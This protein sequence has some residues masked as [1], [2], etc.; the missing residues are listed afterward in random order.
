MEG[1]ESLRKAAARCEGCG[2]CESR[3]PMD[4]PKR[5][6]NALVTSGR[7][8]EAAEL[9]SECTC[10]G[11]C[12][13]R[14]PHGVP[15]TEIVAA[16]R[17]NV[18]YSP[19]EAV[20]KAVKVGSPYGRKE[21]DVNEP[22]EGDVVAVLGCTIRSRRDWTEA[23]VE[24]ASRAGWATLG[25]DEPCC[26]NFARKYGEDVPE[27]NLEAWR[28]LFD[29]YEDVVVFCPGCL[30]MCVEVL[31]RRPRHYA[32]VEKVKFDVPEGAL[33]KSPCHLVRHGVDDSIL[34]RLPVDVPPRRWRCCGGG[35]AVGEPSR[36]V[37]RW[38]MDRVTVTPCPMC[39]RTL[40]KAGVRVVP[41]WTVARV[42]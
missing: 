17:R 40:E 7:L 39:A 28:E 16:V 37:D 6:F 19:R 2:A 3:C 9:V 29:E 25:T 23:A 20:R 34:A 33:Y 42:R 8:D 13:E 31:G 18:G 21:E 38:F 24:L 5:L 22:L 27:N 10:C 11:L 30:D 4:V 32:E 15:H 26:M 41:L 35:G 36:D 12:E 1:V 14:C